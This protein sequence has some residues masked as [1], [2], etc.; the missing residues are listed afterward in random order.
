[1][2]DTTDLSNLGTVTVGMSFNRGGD[3]VTSGE[4]QIMVKH[5]MK[6]AYI[7]IYIYKTQLWLIVGE[8]RKVWGS[9]KTSQLNVKYLNVYVIIVPP[10]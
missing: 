10:I 6:S 7:Y 5:H 2:I 3:L 1:M 9:W 4:V 8:Y